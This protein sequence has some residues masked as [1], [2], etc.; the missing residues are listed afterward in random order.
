[1][2]QIMSVLTLLCLMSLA[3]GKEAGESIEISTQAKLPNDSLIWPLPQSEGAIVVEASF[4]SEK[5]LLKVRQGN[6]MRTER[7]ITYNITKVVNGNYPFKTLVFVCKEKWP[8][9]ESRIEI[10]ALPW[11]F[12]KGTK[13][14]YLKKDDE[15]KYT[16]YYEILSYS[17]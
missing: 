7:L 9:K 13:T 16:D 6:W 3:V 14:F 11:P 5:A 1:M 10:E 4:D 15:C 17:R 8:T 12:R 2:K